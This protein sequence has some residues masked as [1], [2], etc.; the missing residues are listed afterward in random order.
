MINDSQNNK[1]NGLLASDGTLEIG[2]A[3][4]HTF[5]LSYIRHHVLIHNQSLQTLVTNNNKL[6]NQTTSFSNHT[7]TKHRNTFT[8]FIRAAIAFL[9]HLVSAST[10]TCYKEIG[11]DRNGRQSTKELMTA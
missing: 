3:V 6:T 9:R 10:R 5:I 8:S 2:P 4:V 11:A 1:P 7:V